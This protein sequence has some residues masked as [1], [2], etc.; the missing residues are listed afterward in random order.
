[1][2][3]IIHAHAHTETLLHI[4]HY[5][6]RQRKPAEGRERVKEGEMRE[7][8][9]RESAAVHVWEESCLFLD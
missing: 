4:N 1:M 5:Q 6:Q 3:A 9:E 2:H 8:A 7:R